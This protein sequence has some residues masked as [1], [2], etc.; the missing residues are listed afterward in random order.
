MLETRSSTWFITATVV[1]AVFTDIFLYAVIVPVFPFSLVDRIGVAEDKVQHW[2]SILLSVYGAALLVSAP[3]F[4][5]ISDQTSNR[6]APLLIGMIVLGGSTVM[7]C[8][9][10]NLALLI[11]GRLLQGAS[12]GVVWVVGLALLAETVG[13]KNAG[14]A[15]GYVGIGYSLAAL[16]GPLLGGIV[17]DKAG[18]YA[19]FAMSFGMI[20]LDIILR[21]L[22][23]EK[24]IAKRWIPE[25]VVEDVVADEITSGSAK[26]HQFN[27]L[28]PDHADEETGVAVVEKKLLPMLVLLKSKRMQAT[29]WAST[30]GAMTL[31]AFDVTLPL[32]V[33][34]TFHWDSFGAGLVFLSLLVAAFFQP[35]TGWA[36]DNYGPRWIATAGLLIVI[37]PFV[38][39]R[40]VTY[41][42]MSQ[43]VL[44]CA[45]LF[46]IGLGISLT[47]AAAMAEF[48]YICAE[49][50]K[51]KPGSMGKGGAYAQSYSL[52]NISW[53]FGSLVG[54]FWAGGVKQR[55]GF[56]TMGWSFALLCGVIAL[57]TAIYCG[58]S[59][60]EKRRR[61]EQVEQ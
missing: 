10:R 39:L 37:P 21:L 13:K 48:T 1:T 51:R 28:V 53:A 14:Q 33:E 23:V 27:V 44:L 34:E 6:R 54:S 59:I 3:I 55:A 38:C 15:M 18:Y 4:G 9:A 26:A 31:T 58:G 47:L 2:M 49:K 36:V 17:Y 24:K 40:F 45:L 56:G 16:L 42:S 19:V 41:N 8:L 57:P 32:F 25:D 43:K 22:L 29:F 35:V 7:L 12:A 52:F 20:G 61:D 50:E 5:Y 11:I 46:F 60:L 30:A